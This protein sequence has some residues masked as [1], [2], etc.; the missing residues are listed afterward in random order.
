[1]KQKR[2][3]NKPMKSTVFRL[4]PEIHKALRIAAIEVRVAMMVSGHKTRSVFDRYDI[5][6]AAT[7]ICGKSRASLGNTHRTRKQT[8]RLSRYDQINNPLATVWA[9]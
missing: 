6:S 8:Q 2:K 9:Q 1:M 5:V 3:V 4:D 7:M